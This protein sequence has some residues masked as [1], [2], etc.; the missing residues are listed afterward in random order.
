MGK[1]GWGQKR[2]ENK[3]KEGKEQ[4]QGEQNGGGMK[5]VE[6]SKYA[7]GPLQCTLSFCL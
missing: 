3:N 5:E 1:E 7:C 4:G 2:I 6:E